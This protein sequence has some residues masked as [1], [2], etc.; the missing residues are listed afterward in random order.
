MRP[1]PDTLRV[2]THPEIRDAI[3]G[4]RR[5]C[6]VPRT[7]IVSAALRRGILNDRLR[8]KLTDGTRV[9]VL[10]LTDD[11]VTAFEPMREAL[12]E[13]LGDRLSVTRSRRRRRAERDL[14]GLSRQSRTGRFLE[15]AETMKALDDLAKS[16]DVNALLRKAEVLCGSWSFEIRE[17][18]A[19]ALGSAADARAV[20]PLV[21][22]LSDD[23]AE[24]RA[25]AARALSKL[26]S[27]VPHSALADAINPLSYALRDS[28]GLV[29][30][31]AARALA[32]VGGPR[33]VAAL[34]TALPE[35]EPFDQR[36]LRRLLREMDVSP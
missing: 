12:T 2:F 26:A 34:E 19:D 24:V 30:R 8:L 17:S 36:L 32:A 35:L 4:D 14:G 23:H 5:G 15:V 29:V 20:A 3:E 25:R 27:R 22:L 18:A 16:E 21:S 7:E 11:A 1:P 33:S 6:W 10:W 31:A 28:D 13:W 9:K